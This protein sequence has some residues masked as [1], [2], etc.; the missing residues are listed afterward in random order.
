MRDFHLHTNFCDGKNTPEE[1]INKAIE[2]GLSEIGF[3][4]HS[5]TGFDD[6]YCIK[7]DK[8]D[9]YINVVNFL[10]E[11]YKDRIK[12]YCGVEKDYYSD[13]NLSKFD[14]SLGSVH[15]VQRNG[16][17]LEV[18][19]SKEIL[20]NGIKNLYGGDVYALISDYYENVGNLI[21]NG[22]PDIIAHFDLISKFNEDGDLFDENNIRYEY[23]WKKAVD[24]LIKQVNVF[25]I[26]VG[27]ISRGYKT[28]PYPSEKQIEYIKS[29]GGEFV[30]GSDAHTVESIGF[31]IE[32]FQA[33]I[34]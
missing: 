13:C 31:N 25:E 15:Y 7:E 3:V 18:D 6:R 14:Y 33:L 16:V 28:K 29:L 1:M 17:F 19:E 20:V 26:N 8:V 4:H 32:K 5:Y 10:K 12:I 11:K 30:Y 2:F 21:D 9:E 23:A 27:A 22:K 24:K 34:K